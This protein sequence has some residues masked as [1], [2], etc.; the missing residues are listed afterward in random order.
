MITGEN[1]TRLRSDVIK[2][3]QKNADNILKNLD[4]YELIKYNFSTINKNYEIYI[5]RI[6][7]KEEGDG[8]IVC[9]E[10]APT[11][12]TKQEKTSLE[13]CLNLLKN[14]LLYG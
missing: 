13:N 1:N 10:N 14:R 3:I 6:V 7:S 11:L 9:V 12:L 5:S 2:Y 4:E 8:L